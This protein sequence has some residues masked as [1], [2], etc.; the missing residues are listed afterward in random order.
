MTAAAADRPTAIGGRPPDGFAVLRLDEC[1]DRLRANTVVLHRLRRLLSRQGLLPIGHV[2]DLDN[3][4]D[5]IRS[6][7]IS[8]GAHGQFARPEELLSLR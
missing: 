3:Q 6:L 2:R 1:Q 5:P 4:P 7:R 8:K